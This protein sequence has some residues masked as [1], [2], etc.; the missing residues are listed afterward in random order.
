MKST[1][2]SSSVSL[3][4]ICLTLNSLLVVTPGWAYESREYIDAASIMTFADNLSH[5]G[6][7][8]RAVMEYERFL[9]FY[10]EHPDIPKARYKMACSMK[11][12]ANYTPA[13]K[14]FSSLAKQ[15]QGISPGI[16]ASFQKAEIS[17]LK[18]DYQTALKQ[19]AAFLSFYPKHQLA[20]EAK[21]RIIKIEQQSQ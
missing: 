4:L 19:Y 18:H 9:Y 20:E 21:D 1:H 5:Q 3:I 12:T 16:E 11:S 2:L 8:Y 7:H 13:L 10:S 17:Y 15:Y 6:H 14:L